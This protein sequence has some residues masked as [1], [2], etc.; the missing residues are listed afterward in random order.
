VNPID[1]HPNDHQLDGEGEGDRFAA[2]V[3]AAARGEPVP[4]A[5]AD[6]LRRYQETHPAA[7]AEAELWANLG[8]LGAPRAHGA[9]LR[10]ADLAARVLDRL[11]SASR[12]GP[13]ETSAPIQPR[14]PAPAPAPVRTATRRRALAAAIAAIALAATLMVAF[15]AEL[16]DRLSRPPPPSPPA[17]TG[18]VA[19]VAP[20]RLSPSP[21]PPPSLPAPPPV[22]VPAPAPEP[23]PAAAR[24]KTSSEPPARPSA[25]DLLRRAQAYLGAGQTPEAVDAY[26]EL[27]ARYPA[28]VEAS[29]A[30]VSLGR[31][32]LDQGRAAE[33]LD[34]L[35]RY[36]Q[37][38]GPLGEEARYWR[39]EALRRLGRSS[40]EAAAIE[41][42]L[43][44][45]PDSVHAAR[46]R[47]RA[48]ALGGD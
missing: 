22:V 13:Q 38:P 9:E 16:R 47:A 6:F 19:P 26:R 8:A 45:H 28:S 1:Q 46:L 14:R 17:G 2:I 31:L 35:E 42:F 18:E 12:M 27:V 11:G 44:R 41:E 20:P 39:I 37:R 48:E 32:A 25:E 5:D 24:A 10:D 40:I 23:P 21:P 43:S 4:P 36:L 29:A 33:A 30:L 34:D 7:A 3:A 15:A